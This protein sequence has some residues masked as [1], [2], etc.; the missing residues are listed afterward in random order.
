MIG[1]KIMEKRTVFIHNTKDKLKNIN[2]TEY[3]TVTFIGGNKNI[4]DIIKEL[5]K[6]KY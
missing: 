6:D 5:I 1:D 3:R 4:L 2:D